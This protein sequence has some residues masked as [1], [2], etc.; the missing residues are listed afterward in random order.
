MGERVGIVWATHKGFFFI[1]LDLVCALS[2]VITTFDNSVIL[3][4]TLNSIVL[5][6]KYLFIVL[7][8]Y[9]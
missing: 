5:V 3:S 2:S 9:Y 7:I 8:S 1:N 6:S 4:V